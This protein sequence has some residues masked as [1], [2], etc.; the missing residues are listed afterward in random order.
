MEDIRPQHAMLRWSAYEHEHIE[1]ESDW[2]WALGVIAVSGAI[3]SILFHDALFGIL[4]LAA[5]FAFGLLATKHPDLATFEISERG[6]RIDDTL[7]RYH[8]IMAFWVED[9]H[10]R[11]R[12]F[13][14]ISTSK[15]MTPH[16]FIPIES[17][18]PHQVRTLLKTHVKEVPMKEPLAHKLLEFFGL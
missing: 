18:D 4:I 1:R 3:I 7:H 5:A 16:F 9:E 11:G 15:F 17:V 13:L 10:H 6:I 8:E 2:F 12:P 14:L